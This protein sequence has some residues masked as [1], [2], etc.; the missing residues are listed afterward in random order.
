MSLALALWV[1]LAAPP[2]AWTAEQCVVYALDHS[3]KIA[4]AA[5]KVRE[6]EA[7]LAEVESIFWPK[8]DA[9]GFVAPMFTVQGSA[10][11]PDVRRDYT[12]WGPYTRLQATLAW[13]LFTFGRGSHGEDAAAAR[14]DVERARLREA[15][16]VLALE[17]RRLYYLRLFALSMLPSL[18]LAARLVGEAEEKAQALYDA[19]TGEVTQADLMKLRYGALEVQRYTRVARDGADLALAALKHTLGLPEEAALALADERLPDLPAAPPPDLAA[20]LREAAEQRPEWAQIKHGRQA[21]LSLESA[22]KL[23]NAPVLALAGQI[24]AAWAPTRDDTPNPYHYDPYNDLAGGVALAL[25]WDF[26]PALASAKAAGARALQDQVEA[27]SRF[28]ATGIPLQVRKA[29][30]EV[31]RARDLAA[32]TDETVKA[33]RKWL[34]FSAAA[35]RTGTGD[36]RDVLEGLVAFLQ[37]RRTH[38]EQLRDYYTA[39]AELWFAVG[40]STRDKNGLNPR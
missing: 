4:E 23:A 26:D 5:A 8:I 22:E 35:Y 40:R 38:Y 24:E 34:T 13:P 25:K 10:L 18:D 33:G 16:N 21:T 3:P 20:L 12:R 14:A 17:V 28:A 19:G 1:A 30:Q 39:E 31:Q 37:A 29:H 2:E 11:E 27:L 32:I 9:L 6:Y 36:A 7:R 15:R